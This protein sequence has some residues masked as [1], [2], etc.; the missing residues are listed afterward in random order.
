M[1]HSAVAGLRQAIPYLRLYRSQIFVVKCGGEAVE[2]KEHLKSLLEQVSVLHQLGIKVVLVH[3]GGPQAT[4][5][6]RRLG[7]ESKFVNGRRI[8][9][10]GMLESMILALNG[11]ARTQVLSVCA[12]LQLPAI[13]ISGID[14]GLI[15]ATKRP[16][17]E[18]IDFGWVGDIGDVHPNSIRELL[19][20]GYLPVV[21]PLCADA[22]GQVLNVNA[23]S[24]AAALAVALGA[25]KLILITKARGILRD[26]QDAQTLISETDLRGLKA[27][28]HDKTLSD[29]MLPK[30][31]S[32][33]SA[34]QGGVERIHIISYLYPDSLLT[35]VFT[36]EGC[37]TLVTAGMTDD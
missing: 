16:A 17:K 36:N 3:G 23:D 4:E 2:S 21:S 8:T 37:G 1:I 28:E 18:G 12:S 7:A 32:M 24:V 26:A 11:E 29:G 19:N 5:L 22:D 27:L 9:D 31:A 20:L 35:E 25:A 33:E 30:A 15:D 13:G 34:L 6:A 14:A 10:D